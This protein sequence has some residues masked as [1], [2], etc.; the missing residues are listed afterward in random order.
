MK[1]SWRRTPSLRA[2]LLVV[3][4][5]L[6]TVGVAACSSG[7]GSSLSPQERLAAAKKALDDTSGVEIQLAT[8]ALPQGVSGLVSAQGVATHAPAF[9][10]TIKVSAEGITADAQVVAVDGVVHAK[11]PFTTKFVEIEPADYGAPDPA[12]LMSTQ[13]GLSSL[14]TAAEGVEEGKQVRD[15]DQVLSQIVGTVPGT[16]VRAV[17]PSASAKADFD[18]TFTLDDA[19]RATRVVLTGPFY[20]DADDVTYTVDLEKYG[21]QKDITAP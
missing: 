17:I 10:G 14:L 21:V 1:S 7:G 6:A 19:D 3:G 12:D 20:P 8:E 16:A 18:A 5:L 15:G 13:D 9:D 11:L 4:L 2:V